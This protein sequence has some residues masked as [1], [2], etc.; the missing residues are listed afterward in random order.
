MLV[1][2]FYLPGEQDTCSYQFKERDGVMRKP[3][4]VLSQ[5]KKLEELASPCWKHNHTKKKR[6]KKDIGG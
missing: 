4:Q 1:P 5:M 6:G 3:Y 2:H